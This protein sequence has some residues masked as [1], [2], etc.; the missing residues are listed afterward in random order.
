LKYIAV[1]TI[2]EEIWDEPQIANISRN[3]DT[4]ED[5]KSY[6]LI[7]QSHFSNRP[8]FCDAKIKKRKIDSNF[9]IPKNTALNYRGE[10]DQS[11]LERLY[12]YSNSQ[13]IDQV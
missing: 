8:S 11:L 3:R 6:A 5:Q 4:R 13:V 12:A 7:A 1:S 10:N 9:A 2:D